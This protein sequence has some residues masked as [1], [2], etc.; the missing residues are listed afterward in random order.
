MS[1]N[2]ETQIYSDEVYELPVVRDKKNRESI[3]DKVVILPKVNQELEKEMKMNIRTQGFYILRNNREV[4]YGLTL[5][6][7]VK[8]NDLNRIR[9]ELSF[10]ATL[11]SEMGVRFSKDG[12]APNQVISDFLKVE[13]GGQIRSIRNFIKKD[14]KVSEDSLVDHSGSETVIAQRAKLLITPEAEIEERSPRVKKS[15]IEESLENNK[16][17]EKDREN[18][19]KIKTSGNQLMVRV[20]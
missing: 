7:F 20:I 15:D 17:T 19:R 13:I 1:D 2:Q 4:A 10:S 5:D 12:I 14:Q 6:T 11:D 9:M 8:H 16:E 3:R 18:F